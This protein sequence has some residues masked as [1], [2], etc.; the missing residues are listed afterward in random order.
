MS[1][2]DNCRTTAA[3]SNVIRGAN[4]ERKTNSLDSNCVLFPV[5]FDC[6][7]CATLVAT[8]PARWNLMPGGAPAFANAAD[9]PL[10]TSA[11]GP[12]LNPAMFASTR[13]CTARP[14]SEVPTYCTDTT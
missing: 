13:S 11:E 1:E 12:G 3:G 4:T 10:T 6:F 7:C 14:F 5:E 2:P 8:A 9:N